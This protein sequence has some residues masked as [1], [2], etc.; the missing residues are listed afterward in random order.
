MKC[1]YRNCQ[2]ELNFDEKRRD[3][4]FCD[5]KCKVNERTYMRREKKKKLELVEIIK[6]AEKNIES[7]R[8]ILD[9]YKLIYK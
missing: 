1:A 2:Q 9:L 8:Y 5:R 4:K 6:K 7:H 3:T